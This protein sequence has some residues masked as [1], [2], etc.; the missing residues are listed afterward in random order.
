MVDS[1]P[2]PPPLRTSSR[3]TTR[4]RT[5]SDSGPRREAQGT[6]RHRIRIV[7]IMWPDKSMGWDFASRRMRRLYPSRSAPRAKTHAMWS[8]WEYRWKPAAPGTYESLFA[9]TL[10]FLSVGLETGYYV[11]A[12]KNR[13]SLIP[14]GIRLPTGTSRPV[15]ER[16]GLGPLQ[17]GPGQ[18]FDNSSGSACKPRAHSRRLPH[19]D[20]PAPGRTAVGCGSACAPAIDLNHV[21]ASFGAIHLQQQFAVQLVDI[22]HGKR[23]PDRL[24]HP[25]PARRGSIHHRKRLG[26]APLREEIERLHFP[27]HH[28]GL[29]AQLRGLRGCRRLPEFVD[30]RRARVARHRD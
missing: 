18:P 30:H 16:L 4:R 8:L 13:R 22:L 24:R 25:R 20:R 11:Q 27:Q 5:G 23:P 17:Q 2:D 21:I 19:F 9:P 1:D 7:G 12:G 29:L 3:A 14:T 6:W 28:L 26:V 10:R 15:S